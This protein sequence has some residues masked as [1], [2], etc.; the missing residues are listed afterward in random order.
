MSVCTQCPRRCGVDR[1]R[2]EYGE[3]ASPDHIRIAR[4]ALHLWE[5]PAIS[6]TRGSGTIFFSGCNLRCVYCLRPLVPPSRTS[7]PGNVCS[8]ELS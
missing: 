7:F 1:A 5:E 6:G 4:A 2:G 3:C 8:M